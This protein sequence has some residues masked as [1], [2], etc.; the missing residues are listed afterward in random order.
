MIDYENMF[1]SSNLQW[2]IEEEIVSKLNSHSK[3]IDN[4]E[5]IYLISIYSQ[6]EQVKQDLNNV[7]N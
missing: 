1:S 7:T 6:L 5:L 2:L 3:S 4:E